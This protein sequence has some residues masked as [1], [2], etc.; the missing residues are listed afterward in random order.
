VP[1]FGTKVPHLREGSM[2]V[3]F[4]R[5]SVCLSVAY[6]ANNSRTQK[7]SVPKFGMKV[8]HLRRDPHIGFKVKRS[9][10]RVTDGRGHTKMIG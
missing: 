6:M 4:V 5:P 10:A 3:A 8:P 9:K 7:P 1:K 2:N